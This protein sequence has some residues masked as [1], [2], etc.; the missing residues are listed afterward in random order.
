MDASDDW[1]VKDQLRHAD[2]Q[3]AG[4]IAMADAQGDYLLG[5]LLCEAHDHVIR[6]YTDLNPK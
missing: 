2:E 5:A 1:T 3:L 6:R 4:L